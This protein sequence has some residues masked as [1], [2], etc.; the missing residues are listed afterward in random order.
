M[1]WLAV[2]GT[3][4]LAAIPHDS[5]HPWHFRSERMSAASSEHDE[6]QERAHLKLEVGIVGAAWQGL[7]LRIYLQ[8]YGFVIHPLK[9]ISWYGGYV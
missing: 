7:N 2:I 3:D 1:G 5:S 8:R 4:D 9:S 6:R